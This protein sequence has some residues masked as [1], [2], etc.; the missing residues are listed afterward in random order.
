MDRLHKW[1][2]RNE[3]V[4][5]NVHN[6][7]RACFF[8]FFRSNAGSSWFTNDVGNERKEEQKGEHEFGDATAGKLSQIPKSALNKRPKKATQF[9]IR[10]ASSRDL[11]S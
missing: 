6:L 7:L 3:G 8:F 5:G 10:L 4:L 9:L 1:E 2:W 11:E